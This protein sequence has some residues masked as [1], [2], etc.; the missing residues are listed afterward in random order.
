[1]SLGSIAHLQ[2]YFARTGLL[3]GKG[4]QLARERK[5]KGQDA[6]VLM[7]SQE[8]ASF[9]GD[10]LESPSDEALEL[11][12]AWTEAEPMML[13]PTVSTYSHRNH[14]VPPPPD[15]RALR[16]D[17]V[18]ALENALQVL[19]ASHKPVTGEA[20]RNASANG[21]GET[22][23]AGS[24]DNE[25]QGWYEIQGMHILD[26]TTLAI[27]AARV[28]YTAHAQPER[29]AKIK[30]ERK[31]REELFAVLEVLKRWAGRNFAGGLRDDERLAILTWVSGI[32]QTL[33]EERDLEEQ[34]ERK[35]ESWK[36]LDGDWT[37]RERERE[38]A[39]LNCLLANTQNLPSWTPAHD[40]PSLPTPF[41]DRLQDGRDLV[42]LHNRAVK[43][44]KRHFGEIKTFHDDIA[45]PYRRA[46][47]LRYW[48]KAAEIRWEIKLDVDVMGVVHGDSETAWKQFDSAIMKWCQGVRD[49]L[50]RDWKGQSQ[51]PSNT[52]LAELENLPAALS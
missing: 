31:I 30:S 25:H 32:S 14:Y 9:G 20:T 5:K 15:M 7:I 46:D 13:P 16:K 45:K 51:R 18:D 49:E 8:D 2:Y 40:A 17:L 50:A 27:R 23:V 44:S 6:P 38:E 4:G 37:D 41:L 36:W 19:E 35:R 11:G 34:E 48:I 22:M 43:I 29:L 47:N 24:A 33:N 12:E 26:L 1:M 28:Y 52:P 3:D 42:Q 39:F 10:L 21:E